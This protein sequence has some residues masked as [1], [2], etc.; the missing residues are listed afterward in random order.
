MSVRYRKNPLRR[1]HQLNGPGGI[2]QS[3]GPGVQPNFKFDDLPISL[4]ALGRKF[5]TYVPKLRI[6]FTGTIVNADTE[7]RVIPR[8]C[9]TPSLI[10]SVQV[11]G[12]ELGTPVSSTHSLGGILDI[13]QFVRNGGRM[14]SITPGGYD[15]DITL[16]AATGTPSVPSVTPFTHFVDIFPGSNPAA[17]EGHH[18]SPLALFLRPGEI[19]FTCPQSLAN[20][21]DGAGNA[22]FGNTAGQPTVT[23]AGPGGTGSLQITCQACIDPDTEL[24]I[25]HPWQLTRHKANA[26]SGTDSVQL[27]SF[28]ANSTL[29]GVEG[30][31]G[32]HG[33][34]W[35]SSKLVGDAKGSGL[36]GSLTQFAADFLG[37]RQTNDP[38]AVGLDL[39]E[40]FEGTGEPNASEQS[41]YFYPIFDP[42]AGKVINYG[43][44]G[45]G[46]MN[47]T[48]NTPLEALEVFP[49]L[50]P[51]PGFDLSKLLDGVGQP[52]YDLTGVFAGNHYSYVWGCYP[53]SAAKIADLLAIIQRSHIGT[54]MFGTDNL[55][56]ITK[57]AKKQSPV[58]VL[59]FAPWK[60]TYLPL[61]VVPIVASATPAVAS[62]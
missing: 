4:V 53:L 21:D 14:P 28:G 59:P 54:E 50:S 52:S 23:Y 42:D 51:V 39:L 38:Q 13:D 58:E 40:A 49:V 56:T 45:T 44:S 46:T 19:V 3:W 18:T 20:I 47:G 10:N 31:A 34:L 61:K 15:G 7:I 32:I 41:S 36:V 48:L 26:G 6:K 60:A 24:R 9:L 22:P 27:V 30:K 12:T 25:A 57:L 17:N 5:A 2:T 1:W 35:A 62:K 29:T 55:Q 33:V 8:K 43:S 16:A 11:Q 37:L